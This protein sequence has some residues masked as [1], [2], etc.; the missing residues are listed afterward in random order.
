MSKKRTFSIAAAAVAAITAIAV[1]PAFAA[2]PP[3]DRP[4]PGTGPYATTVATAPLSDAEKS[5][6]LFQREEERLAKEL[7][8]AFGEKYGVEEFTRIATSEQRHFDAMGR[9]ITR[10]QLQ[11]PSAGTQVGKYADPELQKRYDDWLQKGNESKE[12][13]FAVGVE[14]ETKDI[15]GLQKSIDVSDN[16]DLD[17]VFGNLK[18]GSEHHLNAFEA[19]SRGETP[20]GMGAGNE[21]GPGPM[22][23]DRMDQGRMGEGR[24][25]QGNGP[26]A[27]HRQGD[28]ENCP[29]R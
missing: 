12:A 11:D 10:Y 5:E 7:Y 25:G 29:A 14:L 8:R 19:L 26:G 28:P 6:I 2:G 21:A 1:A 24:M 16:A 20:Q 18:S 23:D 27:Q 4:E 13:A 9:T 17:R 3:T 15:A 22:R